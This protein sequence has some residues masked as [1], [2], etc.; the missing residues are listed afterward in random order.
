[1]RY[2]DVTGPRPAFAQASCCFTAEDARNCMG[3][4]F[5]TLREAGESTLTPGATI[6]DRS[7]RCVQA[8][9][10]G[11]GTGPSS[12]VV[13]IK[14]R[15]RKCRSMHGVHKRNLQAKK[16]R[17]KWQAPRATTRPFELEWRFKIGYPIQYC[18]S[19]NQWVKGIIT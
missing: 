1:M 9:P 8:A 14:V 15:L 19:F 2:L 11:I 5:S 6:Q 4:P 10:P 12:W 3:W 7:W 17:T 16:V 13:K 18:S